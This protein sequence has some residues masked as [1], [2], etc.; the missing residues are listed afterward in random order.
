MLTTSCR[1]ISHPKLVFILAKPPVLVVL[2]WALVIIM[3][4]LLCSVVVAVAETTSD[5]VAVS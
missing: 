1:Q 5:A 2:I 3:E 4:T